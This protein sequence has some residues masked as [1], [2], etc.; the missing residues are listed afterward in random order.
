MPL[1]AYHVIAAYPVG[2]DAEVAATNHPHCI[3]EPVRPKVKFATFRPDRLGVG[4]PSRD[5]PPLGLL[6][7]AGSTYFALIILA[8]Q[9]INRRSTLHT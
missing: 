9:Y 2:V 7:A 1:A 4:R 3:G 6:S 8:R 5:Y